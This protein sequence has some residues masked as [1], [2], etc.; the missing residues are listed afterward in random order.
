[1]EIQPDAET[2]NVIDKGGGQRSFVRKL[3][4]EVL[5]WN[6]CGIYTKLN[7]ADFIHYLLAFEI[8]CLQETWCLE[9]ND[10]QHILPGYFC[11]FCPAKKSLKA[12]RNMGGVA[13]FIKDYLSQY[14]SRVCE[15]FIYGILI[16]ID[17]GIFCPDKQILLVSLYNPPQGSP[18]YT[19]KTVSGLSEFETLL[20]N[21]EYNLQAYELLL[22]GNLN[23]RTVFAQLESIFE[24]D[25]N[26]MR[27]SKDN[28][29]NAVGKFLLQFCITYSLCIV[30][31]R[32][33]SDKGVGDFT[34]YGGI[35]SSVVDYFICSHSMYE[36]CNNFKVD[37][38]PE[39]D[40]MPLV[41][42][43]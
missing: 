8:I 23:A 13:I 39:S 15:D 11:Y 31:G 6:I 33:G 16:V 28:T 21:S 3:N 7:N 14:I 29:V 30:N 25:V 36:I 20:C 4:V 10:I 1:M 32:V 5:S 19:D 41:L 43:L 9:C 26:T 17:K 22:C 37:A 35:G 34:Y 27:I 42:C 24:N 18:F 38:N 12:G 40:H 2:A